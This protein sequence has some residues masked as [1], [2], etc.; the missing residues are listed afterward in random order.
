MRTKLLLTSIAALFLATGTAYTP[1]KA[2]DW[3]DWDGKP[4]GRL[5]ELARRHC[6]I[7][8]TYHRAHDEPDHVHVNDNH[9][10]D[11]RPDPIIT[12]IIFPAEL[13]ALKKAIRDVERCLRISPP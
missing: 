5:G 12:I 7:H 9:E 8:K 11:L 1:V 6:Y 10:T 3:D 4:H 2:T 13:R